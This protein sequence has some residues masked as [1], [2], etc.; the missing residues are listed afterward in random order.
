MNTPARQAR[1]GVMVNGCVAHVQALGLH[2]VLALDEAHDHLVT[3]RVVAVSLPS[4]RWHH[5]LDRLTSEALASQSSPVGSGAEGDEYTDQFVRGLFTAA[6]AFLAAEANDLEDRISLLGD[7]HRTKEICGRLQDIAHE[8]GD[9]ADA[10]LAQL[11]S[12]TWR[13]LPEITPQS[14]PSQS[15]HTPPPRPGYRQTPA[16]IVLPMAAGSLGVVIAIVVDNLRRNAPLTM[17]IIV[18]AGLLICLGL[19]L[20][21]SWTSQALQA[22]YRHRAE[23]H[24]RLSEEWQAIRAARHHNQCPRCASPLYRQ[25]S[26]LE[27]AANEEAPHDDDWQEY[28]K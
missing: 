2:A 3:A 27:P 15:E 18:S 11:E 23:Q 22:D 24:R 26:Y 20:G 10:L 17:V 5:L 16:R 21:G 13:Q 12:Q 19:L 8:V 9:A 1:F 6:A 28:V 14:D 4:Q 7:D 25:N